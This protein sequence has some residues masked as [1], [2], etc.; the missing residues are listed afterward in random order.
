M[1]WLQLTHN[2]GRLGAALSGVSFATILVFAQLGVLGALNASIVMPY[3]RIDADVMISAADANTLTEGSHAPRQWMFQ[4]LSARGV[5]EAAALYVGAIE[6]SLGDGSTATLQLL[7]LEPSQA[8][9]FKGDLARAAKAT[10]Q[11]DAALID[12]STRGVDLGDLAG[13]SP[14]AP[15]ETEMNGRT[16]EL[17]G[18]FSIGSG[19]S[20]DGYSIVSD[21]TFLRLFPKRSAG[22]PNHLLL[23]TD[24]D[25]DVADVVARIKALLPPDYARVRTLEAAKE[26]DRAYQTTERPTGVIF[27]F[28]VVIGVLVG[29]VI[30]YQVLATDV[31][32]HLAEYATFKAIGY[33][34]RFFLG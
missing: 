19:F 13:L 30:V 6:W 23:K 8:H 7:A 3:E 25:A 9:F 14:D 16:I 29:V 26:E 17:I 21:Q 10:A 24:P 12:V 22:A 4:A 18:S 33:P 11:A 34:H 31:A 15:V 2:R 1:G 5:A 27:G 32:D 28:G 20:A